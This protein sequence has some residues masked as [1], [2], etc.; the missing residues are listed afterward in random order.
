MATRPETTRETGNAATS[1]AMRATSEASRRTLMCS[2]SRPQA[3]RGN[4]SSRAP[5][6]QRWAVSREYRPFP[7][8]PH[9]NL[10]QRWAELPLLKTALGLPRGGRILEIGCGRGVALAYFAA[11][12]SPQS[13]VGVDIDPQA[14]GQARRQLPESV[15][16]VLGDARELPFPD[17]SFDLVVDFGTLFHIA[18]PERAL[19]EIS[20]VLAPQGQ[21]VHETWLSQLISHPFE[22]IKRRQ[23]RPWQIDTLAVERHA[24]LWASQVRI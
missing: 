17:A 8:L 9:K 23:L 15:A 5:L 13:L 19:G 12:L 1:E 4:R 18:H 24:G 21:F 16:L 22:L 3:P 20:R 14:L 11:H 10:A 2:S 7:S 6:R